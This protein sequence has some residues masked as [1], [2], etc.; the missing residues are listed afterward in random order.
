MHAY[1]KPYIEKIESYA[2]MKKEPIELILINIVFQ[3]KVPASAGN[4]DILMSLLQ[5]S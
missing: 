3:E 2:K 1:V 4:N 5:K